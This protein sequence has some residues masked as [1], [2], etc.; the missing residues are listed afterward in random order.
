MN[1]IL[2][3]FCRNANLI[4]SD[5]LQSRYRLEVFSFRMS[6]IVFASINPSFGLGG[7]PPALAL[8]RYGVSATKVEYACSVR[9]QELDL[10]RTIFSSIVFFRNTVV[11][12]PLSSIPNT[13]R[14]C[15]SLEISDN[16]SRTSLLRFVIL[17]TEK[18]RQRKLPSC[19]I[20]TFEIL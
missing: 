17:Y 2:K 4:A 16:K 10:K 3:I 9:N 13:E 1:R 7:V 12:G 20:F 6:P 18:K 19:Y 8:P 11:T 14:S 15:S 5:F